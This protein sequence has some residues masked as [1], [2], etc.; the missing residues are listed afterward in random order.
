MKI[1]IL[2]FHWG[3]NYGGVLQAYA[4]Q[5]YLELLGYEVRI[6]N[7]APRSFRDN[8]W[9][10]F[11]TKNPIVAYNNFMDFFKERAIAKF[12]KQ[13]LKITERYFTPEDLMANTPNCDV[14]I[15]G[16]DQVW[17][18]YG[19]A[20]NQKIYF[21]PFLAQ[22]TKKISYA[23]S[24]GVSS[25]PNHL[26]IEIAPSLKQF[27]RISVRENS[28][29]SILSTIGIEDALLMPDPTLLLNVD[30]Y[31]KLIKKQ[32]YGT[33][34]KYFFYILQD[35]QITINKTYKYCK[36]KYTV[37]S[38]LSLKNRTNGIEKWLS[39]FKY[40]DFIVTNSFH[41]VVFSII[42]KKNFIA[43]PISGK[44]EGMNDRIYTLLDT[45]KLRGRIIDEFDAEKFE[46][47]INKQIDWTSCLEKQKHLQDNAYNFLVESINN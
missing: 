24:F 11:I 42:F 13:H 31:L 9:R 39:Y 43:I 15:V 25:Y 12:R 2:T 37:S 18:P 38:N 3:T 7:Y 34:S 8:F 6:I 26:L 1:G 17:N 32:S 29:L 47:L 14:Y 19:L 36:R 45:F 20:S 23:A 33:Q 28:G 41:G 46:E 22:K 21:L 27:H 10:C 5:T 40:S 30:S 35:N 44:H 16:S 4:L